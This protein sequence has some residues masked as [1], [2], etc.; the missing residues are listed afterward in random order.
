MKIH[1]ILGFW[2]QEKVSNGRNLFKVFNGKV[3]ELENKV[4]CYVEKVKTL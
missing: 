2:R 3:A 4:A 1:L